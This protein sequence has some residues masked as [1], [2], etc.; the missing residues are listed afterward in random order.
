MKKQIWGNATWYL[1]HTMAYKLKPEF[2]DELPVL[3]N[4]IRNI[5]NNLP[6]PSCQTHATH[7]LSQVNVDFIVS[8][9]ENLINFLHAFH[10]IVNNRIG[11]PTFSIEDHDKLYAK[12]NTVSIIKYFL[13]VMDE[14]DNNEKL[15]LSSFHRKKTNNIARDYFT[16]NIHKF[17]A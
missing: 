6:C 8:T 10:N 5:C 2:K 7:F 3:F 11:A 13:S 17:Y 15:M 1:F 14:N 12:A 4:L 9:K 16:N